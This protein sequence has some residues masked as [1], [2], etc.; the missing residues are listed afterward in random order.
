MSIYI[1]NAGYHAYLL[2]VWCEDT[3]RENRWRLSLEDAHTGGRT[4][5][6]GLQPLC[7]F[8]TQHMKT[9]DAPDANNADANTPNLNHEKDS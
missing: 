3:R 1:R 8:L 7:D 5:F 9:I 2:R 6:A 4:G